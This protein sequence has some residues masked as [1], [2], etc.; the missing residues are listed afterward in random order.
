MSSSASVGSGRD[1]CPSCQVCGGEASGFHYGVDS[2]EGCK[3]FF[4]RCIT[5]GMTNRCANDEK[6]EITPFSRNS[7]QFCRLKKCFDVGMSREGSRLGRRPKRL[8]GCHGLETK[9]SPK[10]SDVHQSPACSSKMSSFG[11]LTAEGNALLQRLDSSA[12]EKSRLSISSEGEQGELTS[13]HSDY[14]LNLPSISKDG[15]YY[16]SASYPSS[17]ND[18][19]S[20]SCRKSHPSASSSAVASGIMKTEPYLSDVVHLPAKMKLQDS[21]LPFSSSMER[22]GCLRPANEPAICGTEPCG[23]ELPRNMTTCWSD[24]VEPLSGVGSSGRIVKNMNR[25]YGHVPET[26]TLSGQAGFI[27]REVRESDES[28]VCDEAAV[29]AFIDCPLSDLCTSQDSSFAYE[30]DN[31]FV[32]SSE[33]FCYD[34]TVKEVKWDSYRGRFTDR[35]SQSKGLGATST[36]TTWNAEISEPFR[37]ADD[38]LAL[39]CTSS[40]PEEVA[41]PGSASIEVLIAEAVKPPDWVKMRL[42]RHVVETVVEAHLNTCNYTSDKVALGIQRYKEMSMKGQPKKD[43]DPSKVWT[44]FVDNMA[45]VIKRVV[46]FSKKIPGMFYLL[47]SFCQIRSSG[48]VR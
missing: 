5:Q 30:N 32:N 40:E 31:S 45:P 35:I 39:P 18:Q 47:L 42:I 20:L 38:K 22:P 7:C 29:R 6:C 24:Y 46:K 33:G 12:S 14:Y 19:H 36:P 34:R 21:R 26:M 27:K 44:Q 11:Q 2:C 8:K 3:G 28:A 13:S 23:A 37:V 1:S 10:V 15:C 9:P 41:F 43:K 17:A 4:R 48:Q 25:G 16:R